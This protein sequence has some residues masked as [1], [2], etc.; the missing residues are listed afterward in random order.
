MCQTTAADG[1]LKGTRLLS[2]WPL[3]SSRLHRCALPPREGISDRERELSVLYVCCGVDSFI[4][5]VPRSCTRC[6]FQK[7][8]GNSLVVSQVRRLDRMGITTDTGLSIESARINTS[9]ISRLFFNLCSF[10]FS[11]CTSCS[12]LSIA[13]LLHPFSYPYIR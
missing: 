2:A 9:S 3:L 5:F 1:R 10:S 4:S 7:G 11:L 12:S 8:P 6:H 13:L